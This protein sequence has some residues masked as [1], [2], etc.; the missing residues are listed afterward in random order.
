M[1]TMLRLSPG[2]GMWTLICGAGKTNSPQSSAHEGEIWW[3]SG[4]TDVKQEGLLAWRSTLCIVQTHPHPYRHID[5]VQ[6]SSTC[7]FGI[8]SMERFRLRMFSSVTS[9]RTLIQSVWFVLLCHVNTESLLKSTCTYSFVRFTL[10]LPRQLLYR[11]LRG[12]FQ[13]YCRRGIWPCKV[14]MYI[15]ASTEKSVVNNLR[16]LMQPL[17]LHEVRIPTHSM[18]TCW[19]YLS[20]TKGQLPVSQDVI[21]SPS[22]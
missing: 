14:S 7:V 18:Y 10:A 19:I 21:L 3:W 5:I 22:A 12:W 4:L 20:G 6:H 13:Y 9:F 1:Y 15:I 11:W 16:G 17:R 8:V 2:A